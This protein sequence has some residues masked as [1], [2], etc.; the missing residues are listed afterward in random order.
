MTRSSK[1]LTHPLFVIFRIILSLSLMIMPVTPR[2][3]GAQVAPEA[4]QLTQGGPTNVGGV[5]GAD[6]LWTGAKSPYR[7]VGDIV[8]ASGVTLT[9]QP[10]VQVEFIGNYFLDAQGTLNAVGMP[11]RQIVFKSGIGYPKSGRWNFLQIQ[12][13]S[14]LNYVTIDGAAD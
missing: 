4:A 12:G 3:A 13:N 6:P 7:V 8:V 14:R 5:F 11:S 9:I 1:R 2:E 10:G